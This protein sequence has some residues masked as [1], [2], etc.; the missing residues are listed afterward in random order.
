MEIQ[1]ERV[2][3]AGRRER[4]ELGVTLR[5][6]DPIRSGACALATPSTD[7]ASCRRRGALRN[8][9]GGIGATVGPVPLTIPVTI[10]STYTYT[11]IYI[12]THAHIQHIVY[13]YKPL[14][15]LSVFLSVC[16]SF[17]L[18]SSLFSLLSS[19]FSLSLCLSL[20]SSQS[21]RLASGSATRDRT[22]GE[23]RAE[24]IETPVAL[25]RASSRRSGAH[26]RARE[27]SSPD[28]V[29]FSRC[30]RAGPLLGALIHGSRDRVP[31]GYTERH[32][33]QW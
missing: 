16:L 17:S 29:N 21:D 20:F 19:L 4:A 11:Y 32:T 30:E 7:E 9:V 22:E 31:L 1:R 14:S 18:L 8:V 12:Y 6:I 23:E 27:R 24:C 26:T 15:L 3:T 25:S 10:P 28:A 13:I 5:T 2:C 33:S